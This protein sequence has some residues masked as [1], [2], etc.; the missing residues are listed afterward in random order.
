[1]LESM[2]EVQ[3]YTVKL[4][5]YLFLLIAN[6][7][8]LHLPTVLTNITIF[9]NPIFLN[10]EVITLKCTMFLAS[11]AYLMLREGWIHTDYRYVKIYQDNV[12]LMSVNASML[13]SLFSDT[14]LFLTIWYLKYTFCN[15]KIWFT[16]WKVRAA[17]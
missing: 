16:W 4:K 13:Y 14:K 3:D 8:D 12:R 17:S 15:W 1:M 11:S 6:N 10:G 5:M 2:F 9:Q 7:V